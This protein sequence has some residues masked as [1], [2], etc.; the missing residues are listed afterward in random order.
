[1]WLGFVKYPQHQR[2]Q[3]RSN[4]GIGQNMPDSLRKPEMASHIWKEDPRDQTG[5]SS[6]SFQT[7]TIR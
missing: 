6:T 4:R 2:T 3:P 7:T 5:Y 1:M